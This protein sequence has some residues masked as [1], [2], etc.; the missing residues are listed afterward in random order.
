MRYA[1]TDD[2]KEFAKQ[3][4]RAGQ[5]PAAW[6]RS[7]GRLRDAAEAI[8]KHELP[9]E[10]SYSHAFKI[11]DEEALAESVRND[12]GVGAADIKAIAPNYGGYFALPPPGARAARQPWCALTLCQ[13]VMPQRARSALHRRCDAGGPAHPIPRRGAS[14]PPDPSPASRSAIIGRPVRPRHD[15]SIRACAPG[16]AG[17]RRSRRLALRSPASRRQPS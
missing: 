6:L 7:A 1:V 10:R 3:L 5:Q 11:A 16:N 15:Q 9:A 8:L 14:V 12:T 17:V 2:P 4:F 13:P